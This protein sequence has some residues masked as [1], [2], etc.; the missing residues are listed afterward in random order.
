MQ[1]IVA[2]FYDIIQPNT[3][4]ELNSCRYNYMAA[5]V[6]YRQGGKAWMPS[7]KEQLGKC[8]SGQ[9]TCEDCTKTDLNLVYNVHFTNCRKPW[10]CPS[11]AF[12]TRSGY[13]NF[14]MNP[15]LNTSK[16]NIKGLSTYIDL[17]ITPYGTCMKLHQIWHSY[18]RDLEDKLY[19]I[20][21]D[22]DIISAR[23]GDFERDFFLGYCEDV[24]K[25]KAMNI[26]GKSTLL[27]V[28]EIWN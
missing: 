27:H 28:Q 22:S 3:S 23:S 9:T 5:D 4:I 8:R 2:Y 19:K 21:Q 11:K 10:T 25:Y 17:N 14:E 16:M 26:Y 7:R 13:Y 12:N 6:M 18:R 24:G 15:Q 20:T 1:G